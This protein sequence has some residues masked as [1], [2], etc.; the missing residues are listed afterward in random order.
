ME[1]APRGPGEERLRASLRRHR[2]SPST[3]LRVRRDNP[4]LYD[5]DWGWWVEKRLRRLESSMRWLVGLAGAALAAEAIRVALQ[6][7]GLGP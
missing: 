7:L 4:Q 5:G 1:E 2:D 6:T 3:L